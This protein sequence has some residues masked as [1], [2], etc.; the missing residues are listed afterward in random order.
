MRI[1][2][3]F[4][5]IVSAIMLAMSVSVCAAEEKD[6]SVSNIL[7][8]TE[9][10][11]LAGDVT[12]TVVATADFTNNGT[13]EQNAQMIVCTY[14]SNNLMTHLY[15]GDIV[16]LAAGASDVKVD[17]SFAY[18]AG[19]KV[20][21]F[22]IDNMGGLNLYTK[23]ATMLS[24]TTAL[25][26]IAIDG[27]RIEYSDTEDL[28]VLGY[29]DKTSVD[30][31]A[32]AADGGSV[33]KGGGKVKLPSQVVIGV[34]SPYGDKREIK[35]CL[36]KEKTDL[37]ALG[38]VKYSVGETEYEI[39][40]FD[41]AKTEYEVVLPDDT[42]YAKVGEVQTVFDAADTE[43][44]VEDIDH[45]DK[46]YGG[47]SY[48]PGSYTMAGS[49]VRKSIDGSIP[50][51]NEETK[52]RINVSYTDES[53]ETYTQTY[54]ISFKSK[55]PRLTAFNINAGAAGDTYKPVFISGAAMNNDGGSSVTADRVWI[56][57]NICKEFV[58][59]SVFQSEIIDN[60]K[61]D[62]WYVKNNRGEYFNFTAD[63]AGT[64]YVVTT[65]TGALENTQEYIDAGWS[66]VTN[67][68]TINKDVWS[69][70]D[71]TWN[72][73]DDFLYFRR[74]ELKDDDFKND[75]I[76]GAN[77]NYGDFSNVYKID[78]KAGQSVS[79]M[80]GGDMG[81]LKDDGT[82]ASTVKR[83]GLVVVIVWDK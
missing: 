15:Q 34:E 61:G 29:A 17:C 2:H 45:S 30:V 81:G 60:R 46:T 3:I 8:E 11:A 14:D 49:A 53:K 16:K 25:S 52:A 33:V 68:S 56:V 71:K 26:G 42:F 19:T 57:G 4:L 41:P 22:L 74:Y 83:A 64:A 73:Y 31:T 24:N 65:S 48:V 13:A 39:K 78:F 70:V 80:H 51:K 58:G 54:T 79:V 44:Q 66:E 62:T 12:G 63:T 76:A 77:S 28:Y 36:Y 35:L 82:P 5:M 20:K 21:A 6:L 37:C 72:D 10:G 38:G 50:I 18:T 23:S 40:D 1:K 75:Y 43:M 27:N 69:T 59:A 55:Q 67:K 7:F 47:I 9:D 32:F